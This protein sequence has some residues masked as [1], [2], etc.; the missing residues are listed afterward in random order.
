MTVIRQNLFWAFAYNVLLIPVAVGVLYPSFGITISPALAAGA[1]ALSSVSVVSN[2]LRLRR[3]DVRPGAERTGRRTVGARLRDASFLA[4][5][6]LFAVGVAGGVLAADRAI[7]ASAQHVTVTA[8]AV[9]FV[10]DELRVRAGDWVSLSLVN[11]DPVFHDLMVEGV[12]NVDTPARPGQTS[13]IRFIMDEPG[14]YEFMC[15]VPGHA[16]AGMV[17]TLIVE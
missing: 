8:E 4:V 14:T 3:L 11:E 6:A 7:E 1:M 12:E 10:P 2:S 16:E 15:S 17:G 5:T 13:S 9:R